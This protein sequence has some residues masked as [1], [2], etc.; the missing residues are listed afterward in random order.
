MIHKIGGIFALFSF[1]YRYGFL[2][3]T[4]GSLGFVGSRFD[5]LTMFMHMLLAASAIQ[6]RVP[7]QRQHRRPTMIWREYLLHAVA[8]TARCCLIYALGFW[9]PN[10]GAGVRYAA[11]MA[12]HVVAD[13][14]TVAYG[15]DG[16]T[17]IRGRDNTVNVFVTKMRRGYSF[18]QFLALASHLTPSPRV[19]DMGYNTIIAIQSS[20]FLMTL[21]RKGLASWQTHFK[22][23]SLALLVSSSYIIG[24]FT[25]DY[26]ARFGLLF[27]AMTA[28]A[29]RLRTWGVGKYTLWALFAGGMAVVFGGVAALQ[30]RALFSFSA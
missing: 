17:T 1:F 13:R 24:A 26:G 11:T 6:F 23:Y 9:A 18:Y 16:E 28:V 20:A 5:W 10:A 4:T 3:P 25:Y 22:L 12:M 27:V 14:I 29:F 21:N 15:K 8:F 19:M 7:T 30:P 2:M